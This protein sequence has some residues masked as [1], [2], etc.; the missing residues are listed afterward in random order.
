MNEDQLRA[1]LR[2]ERELFNQELAKFYGKLS[3]RFDHLDATKADRSQVE[4]LQATMDGVAN[5]LDVDEQERAAM[6]RQLDR[7]EKWITRAAPKL[8]VSYDGGA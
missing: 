4:R 5:R 1:I 8:D 6:N 2:E 3:Q 7:H